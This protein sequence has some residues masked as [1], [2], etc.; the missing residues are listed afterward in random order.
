MRPS[1]TLPVLVTSA[2]LIAMP[3]ISHAGQT[4]TKLDSNGNLM[5]EVAPQSAMIANTATFKMMHDGPIVMPPGDT[6]ACNGNTEGAVRYNKASKNFEGCDGNNWRSFWPK[7]LSGNFAGWPDAIMCNINANMILVLIH[8][9]IAT[10]YAGLGNV[11]IYHSAGT[12][13]GDT[14]AI[15]FDL[16]GNYKDATGVWPSAVLGAGDCA[17]SMTNII[18]AGRT[19]NFAAPYPH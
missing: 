11:H 5:F 18:N 8:D 14:I 9:E 3:I 4:Q 13:T 6:A 12:Y 19:F 15:A 17:T 2:F 10:P 1:F 7:G 16:S